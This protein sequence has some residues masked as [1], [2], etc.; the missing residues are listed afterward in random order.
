MSPGERLR[1]HLEA[2]EELD[3]HG[4]LRGKI[5]GTDQTVVFTLG[6][7]V[8]GDASPEFDALA[9]KLGLGIDDS[10]APRAGREVERDVL[11]WPADLAE[12]SDLAWNALCARRSDLDARRFL[13]PFGSA[14]AWLQAREDGRLATVPLDR[15]RMVR[16]LARC[17]RWLRVSDSGANPIPPPR[18]VADDL[19]V[20]PDPPLPRLERIVEV[21]ILAPDGSVHEAPGYDPASRCF[22]APATGLEVPKVADAPGV[23]AV[24]RARGLLFEVVEDFPFSGP[25]EGACERGHAL[26]LLL[27][28]FVRA[29]VGGPTPLHLFEAPTPGTGKTLLAQALTVPALGDSELAAMAE[30]RDFDEWRKRLTAKLRG[31]PEFLLID[32]IRRRLDSPALAMTLT[33]MVVEDRLLGVSEMVRLPVRCGFLATANNPMLSDEMTRRSVRIHLDSG[34]EYPEEG[35]RFRH[36]DLLA[37]ARERRGELIWAALTLARAW[38]AAGQPAP[39]RKLGG[40]ESWSEVVGGILEH[41]SIGGFLGNLE[42]L[43]EAGQDTSQADFLRGAWAACERPLH[44]PRGDRPRPRALQHRRG[45]GRRARQ[46]RGLQAAR[47]GG[48][49]A[50]GSRVAPRDQHA[51]GRPAL[52]RRAGPRACARPQTIPRIPRIGPRICGACGTCG[53]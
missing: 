16:L 49:A 12:T 32:N 43:R 35:R 31:A 6:G 30:A 1:D 2:V 19:L 23:D 27:L 36:P 48:P 25:Q 42:E 26:A 20:D 40:F 51:R 45:H 8:W 3:G 24:E 13:C 18:E 10:G 17:G 21:P 41:A 7:E 14:V 39:A 33:A 37:W 52:D 38:I 4:R 9:A 11:T 28:P 5:P 50:R 44:E 53:A 46:P 29:L 34:L 22:F 15:R 47:A